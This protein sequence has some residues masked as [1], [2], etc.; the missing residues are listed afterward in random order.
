MGAAGPPGR[1]LGGRAGRGRRL[2]QRDREDRSHPLPGAHR[3]QAVRPGRERQPGA[4]RPGLP[5]GGVAGHRGE[6]VPHRGRLLDVGRPRQRGHPVL[7]DPAGLGR[8]GRGDRGRRRHEIHPGGQRR[9]PDLRD[10]RQQLAGQERALD[11]LRGDD[12]HQRRR[13][14]HLQRDDGDRTTAGRPIR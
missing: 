2:R 13:T 14:I 4:L 8:R 9:Q 7:P 11:P 3:L 5:H 6:P 1:H 10:P 12:R